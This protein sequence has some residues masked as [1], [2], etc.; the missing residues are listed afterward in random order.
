MTDGRLTRRIGRLLRLER[1]LAG[2]TQ[3]ALAERAA[4]SQQSVS[5]LETGAFAPTT[6]V[7]ERLFGA[8]GLQLR[9]DVEPRDADLDA[10]IAAAGEV[11]DEHVEVLLHG[12][13]VL[14][15]NI[16]LRYL[17]DGELAAY[18]HG[19]PVRPT[20]FD[21]AVAEEDLDSLA[22]WI[23]VLPNCRRWSERWRD[24]SGYDVDPRSPGPL[25]WLT[26]FGE[27]RVRLV[28][29]M[30]TPVTVVV[31]D[32]AYPVR[33]LLEVERDDPQ[34]ARVVRRLRA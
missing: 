5:R 15:R 10:A 3:R 7:V 18:L 24:F 11:D 13:G 34:I 26:P 4:V 22:D 29:V 9:V 25:R 2:L 23:C 6:T 31:A 21:L 1:E 30:P 20:R 27:L 14:L 33:P 12:L 17:I 16:N 8:L 32:R 19:V 28:P